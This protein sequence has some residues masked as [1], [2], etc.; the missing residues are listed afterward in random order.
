MG[1]ANSARRCKSSGSLAMFR[2]IVVNER[3]L[4]LGGRSCQGPQHASV[5]V[6]GT[7]LPKYVLEKLA[8]G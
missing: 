1:F 7:E 3:L 5:C 6:R 4:A 2:A 8:T